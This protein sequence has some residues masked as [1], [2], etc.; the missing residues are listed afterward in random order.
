MCVE[1]YG[2]EPVVWNRSKLLSSLTMIH[3]QKEEGG[4]R[5]SPAQLN[6]PFS[7]KLFKREALCTREPPPT[8]QHKVQWSSSTVACISCP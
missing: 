8:T 1:F 7:G 3:R 6:E 5:H 2:A 4:G